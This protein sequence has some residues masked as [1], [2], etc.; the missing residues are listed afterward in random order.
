M[1]GGAAYNYQTRRKMGLVPG[2]RLGAYEIVALLGAGGMGE[3]YRA[4]DT[5]LNRD[6][7]LKILPDAFTDDPDRLARFKREAQVLAS[8]NHP[9]IA[10]I[11]GF[12]DSNATQALV[13][14]LVEGPTLAD[15]IAHG[16][17]PLDEA[18]PIARQIAEALE[19]AH[20]R[21]I[22]HRD[23]KPAN[24]K[25]RPDATVKVLDFGLARALDPTS[26]HPGTGSMRSSPT[27]TSPAM[28]QAGVML[29]TAAY[30]SPEQ[31]R[32]KPAD[33][34]SDI[35]AFGCVLFE[36]L[37]GTRAFHGDEVSDTLA[38]VL[39]DD[40]PW[41]QLPVETPRHVR[42]TLRRCLEKDRKRR[43][44]DIADVQ[45]E[46]L[47]PHEEP[48][49]PAAGAPRN[50]FRRP[51]VAWTSFAIAAIAVVAAGALATSSLRSEAVERRPVRFSI[52]PPD[53]MVVALENAVGGAARLPLA[54]SPDGRHVV[55]VGRDKG[56]RA[57][58]WIRPLESLHARELP[59]TEN[60][61]NPFWSHDSKSIGFFADG[62]LKRLAIDGGIPVSLCD[63][64]SLNSATWSRAG[65]IVVSRAGG[66]GGGALLK[67]PEGGGVPVPASELID[68]ESLHV[69][70]F[71]L[72]DGKHFL[73]RAQQ[74]GL[75]EAK[76]VIGSVDTLE[77]RVL[78]DRADMG[79]IVYA[80]GH[81][82]FM[83]QSALLAQPFDVEALQFTG[84][85]VPVADGVQTNQTAA[86]VGV[87][88]A[89]ENGILVYQT[90]DAAIGARLAWVDRGG[91]PLAT[92]GEPAAYGDIQ[93][94][95]DE[96]QASVSIADPQL[97]T[98]DLYLV[99]LKNGQPTK[100]TFSPR[101][102][103]SSV[104][105]PDGTSLVFNSLESGR[106][107]LIQKH[108]TGS[109]NE[110]QLLSNVPNGVPWSWSRD[111]HYIVYGVGPTAA[112]DLWIL[113][114]FG[115]RK[116]FPMFET[117]IIETQAQFS[118]DGRTLAYVALGP[119]GPEVYAVP[120]PGPG[121]T[122]LI[123][124]GGGSEPRWRGDGKEIYYLQNRTLMAAT[125]TAGTPL[126]V[127][128]LQELFDVES[129]VSPRLNYAVSADGLRFLVISRGEAGSGAMT[130]VLNWTTTLQQ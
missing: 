31:A 88:S 99:D 14:E 97:Q 90:G 114:M 38:A 95:P 80:D 78:I 120:F 25:L 13:L 129:I 87:F 2:I 68:N 85:P 3:V 111:G 41:N 9:N 96:T 70:P 39:R 27:I 71:F 10:A 124:K 26:S 98:R 21:G 122:V 49:A 125:L 84:D 115:D 46:L 20:E 52:Q 113:P 16:P 63:L 12:E 105:S 40:P 110:E 79:N 93:L 77:R 57:R 5:K 11:Y 118:P 128:S 107:Q 54:I 22:I 75:S 44:A 106:A 53:G 94:S 61:I 48:E 69:R 100:L 42:R 37:T 56:G 33:K 51:A 50:I 109:G 19:A 59:G 18:L 92:I 76:I 103:Q 29:G 102:E 30:M 34:R 112:P 91:K 8:L 130:V 119:G 55:L 126:R 4:R 81:V 60:A 45:L 121:A 1:I 23:L 6:V 108:L 116:S 35:W 123:S 47:W 86:P 43:F 83:R 28:T 101:T 73:Y 64:P 32:G 66:G 7:A 82:L 89:S 127:T 24:I 36:L 104:W 15:R 65:I 62:K 58:L 74:A 117:P 67:V 17:I 72:P